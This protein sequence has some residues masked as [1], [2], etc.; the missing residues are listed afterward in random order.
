MHG[1]SQDFQTNWLEKTLTLNG[2]TLKIDVN[3]LIIR[4]IG[5][6]MAGT[7]DAAFVGPSVWVGWFV[8]FEDV[9]HKDR[10]ET[11]CVKKQPGVPKFSRELIRSYPERQEAWKSI[12]ILMDQWSVAKFAWRAY[13]YIFYMMLY[14]YIYVY[15]THYWLSN[16]T[17]IFALILCTW[18][19]DLCVCVLHMSLYVCSIYRD[20]CTQ[21]SLTPLSNIWMI[22]GMVFPQDE[23]LGQIW[24]QEVCGASANL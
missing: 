9:Y 6:K 10:G 17:G 14:L 19:V 16:N 18:F 22:M 2:G 15:T 3:Q 1:T 12:E 20:P 13:I 24:C 23:Y 8:D 4:P 11:E 5:Q 21:V 7:W